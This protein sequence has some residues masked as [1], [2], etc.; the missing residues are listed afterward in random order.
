MRF[1]R[2]GGG[3]CG[4]SRAAR[5]SRGVCAALER[6]SIEAGWLK[7]AAGVGLPV[8]GLAEARTDEEI[9]AACAA[10]ARELAAAKGIPLAGGDPRTPADLAKRFHDFSPTVWDWSSAAVEDLLEYYPDIEG[11]IRVDCVQPVNRNLGGGSDIFWLLGNGARASGIDLL[12]GKL[13]SGGWSGLRDAWVAARRCLDRWLL[14]PLVP[15]VFEYLLRGRPPAVICRR[16]EVSPQALAYAG[17][18]PSFSAEEA[19]LPRRLAPQLVLEVFEGWRT[20]LRAVGWD[21]TRAGVGG[22]R[23]RTGC[24]M[25]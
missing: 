17:P 15:I 14:Y 21:W 10:A 16:T 8:P 9:V 25:N 11:D 23:R 12:Q 13:V 7:D 20:R 3:G 4:L 5:R 22:G 18:A 2:G 19:R 6:P 1:W 24:F